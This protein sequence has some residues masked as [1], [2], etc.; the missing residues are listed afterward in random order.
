MLRINCAIVVGAIFACTNV[1]A[2]QAVVDA[3]ATV[4]LYRKDNDFFIYSF[5][6]S[7]TLSVRFAPA[8]SADPPKDLPKIAALRKNRYMILKL[9]PGRYWFDTRGMDGKLDIEV[10]PGDER[11]LRL[12]AGNHCPTEDDSIGYST[13]E[14]RS[15]GMYVTWSSIAR[16]ELKKMKPI[17]KGDVSDHKL[18]TIPP[19]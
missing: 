6:F 10:G 7:R 16:T 2:Q 13:C 12:D 17:S 8:N 18:V 1:F 5:A 3:K 4:Y 9:D 14:S 11:F 19:K 15:A